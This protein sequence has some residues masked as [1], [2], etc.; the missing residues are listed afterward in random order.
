MTTTTNRIR[1]RSAT[2]V[3]AIAALAA[4]ALWPPTPA[5]AAVTTTAITARV[6]TSTGGSQA[7]AGASGVVKV[8][9]TGRYVFFHTATSL[10]AGDSNGKQDVYRKDRLTGTTTRVSLLGTST[11]LTVASEVCDVTANGR[12]VGF[13]T[14]APG[15]PTAIANQLFVRDLQSGET[16]LVSQNDGEHADAGVEAN[17]C[18][19]SDDGT[20][21]VFTSD[22]SNLGGGTAGLADVFL[23]RRDIDDTQLM[24]RNSAGVAANAGSG[25]PAI[26]ANGG[27]VAFTS[28]ATNLTAPLE[29][30]DDFDVFVRVLATNTTS[31]VST[32]GAGSAGVGDSQSPT[33]SSEGRYVGFSS[34]ASNLVAE[35][36]NGV[37]D[38]FRKDR[39]TGATVR[40]SVSSSGVEADDVA[41]L[42][43]ISDDGRYLA[44]TSEASTLYAADV[45]GV[46]DV[47]RRDVQLGKTDLASRR[48]GSISP[49][50]DSSWYGPSISADGRVV[51]FASHATDLVP[52][53]TNATWDAFVRD[54]GLD[55]AP[56]ASL[57]AFAAQ[58][59]NDFAAPGTAPTPATVDAKAQ[60]LV[61]GA[62][63][64][65]GLIVD[66]ARNEAWA[67]KRGP[68]VR[69]Y[70]AFF[71]RAPDLGGMTYWTDQLTGAK[72][73][74]AV[75]AQFA[76]S[77][78]FQT[79][80]GSKT[81]QQFVTLIYQN[82]FE[83]DPDP[84][85]LTY[86]TN[87]LA[88]GQK[89]RGDV[90]VSF[91]E[92][93]EG[94][95]DLAPQ[96]DTVL[97]TLGM[98]RTMPTKATLLDQKAK[99]EAGGVAEQYAALLRTHPAYAARITP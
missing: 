69:L 11:Q 79:K 15:S 99:R 85:G 47:Y 92:S 91:S 90:M 3:A 24:S 73:L 38:V 63:S 8:D 62:R 9:G 52:G 37:S 34:D 71:L 60:L 7:A 16:E 65:D 81:D 44:F 12:F 31:R 5:A 4:T 94:K 87:K 33:L 21:V 83:R 17:G 53:D 6:S 64:P 97:I 80:Y 28:R 70:W 27:V 39:Q 22:A 49:G 88:T 68:L 32:D 2:T 66:Q 74:A 75:A 35:D 89:T 58:Q 45:N 67:A 1:R 29:A 72:T 95:R 19:I 98:V 20:R 36:D 14:S 51:A 23:R 46:D 18:G 76:K 56:F 61:T 78:E 10:V 40:A 55:H 93:S 26:S 42:P 41:N 50:N 57:K 25:Q 13:F 96:A 54:F 77:S 43:E 84:G 48:S 82:I 86:W 59:L 30:D